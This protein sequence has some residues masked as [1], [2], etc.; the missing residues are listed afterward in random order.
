MGVLHVRSPSMNFMSL[1]IQGLAQKAKKDWV[2]EL[3]VNNKVNFLSLQETKMETIELFCIKRCWGIFAFDYV[4]SASVGNLSGILC[5]WDP[6]LFQKT[7]ITVSDY[8]VMIRGVWVPNGKKLRII[9]VYAHQELNEKKMLWDYISHVMSNWKCDVVI[10]GDFN[11][12]RKKAE[13]FGLVFNVQGA[14]A[15]N[16]FIS[17]ASLEEVPLGGCSFTWC[18][19]S[20]TKMSKLDRFLISE[21]LMSACPNISAITLDR[22]LSDHRPI[23][24]CES[25]YDY[26]PVPFRFF[27][28]WF[29]M[30]GFDKFV[31]ES[32]K[33]APVAEINA[34]I[35]M[36]KKLKYLKEKIRVW[37]KNK[38]ECP[39]NS[40]RNLKAEL[41]SVIDKGKGDDDVAIE[42]VENSKY[43][44]GILNKKRSQLAI[45]GILVDGNWID[46]PGLVKTDLE[47]E[48]IKEEIKRAVWDCGIDK[49]S[50]PD[51]F[52]FGFYRCVVV[53]LEAQ[54]ANMANTDKNTRTSKT[55]EARKGTNN[56]KQNFDDRRNTTTNNDNNYS[57]NR[58]NNN[59]RDNHNN[60]NL[61]NDY[62]QQENRKQETIRTYAATPTENKRYTKKYHGNLTLVQDAP[63][64]TPEFAQASVR[65][66]TMEKGHYKSQCS[67]TDNS[68]F[69]ISK[70]YLCDKSL[71]IPMKEIW[72]D[73][74]LNFVEEPVEIMDRE[75]K[76]LRRSSI[77]IVKV[78][79]NSE[80]T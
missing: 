38:K 59:Y 62:H 41:D 35:K 17:N 69:H 25:H 71:V 9:L 14:D 70:K 13:R 42:G 48:V 49:S 63:C 60:H 76:Q 7:N 54:A 32:W 2:K 61:N 79:W 64:I 27:H 58:N 53:A 50:G 10:M 21:S 12:V 56:H 55:Q 52:T 15:F 34:L 30:E 1:N 45:R 20:A 74:K 36:M 72:L 16:L 39:N 68:T 29:E 11:E 43:Y 67:K 4:Y 44:H 3:C 33:E 19:K 78:R 37:N 57:N 6:K 46:S 26:G 47:C 28:Y 22:Y 51:G 66:A 40:K 75:V 18:H 24:M 80:F 31:E 23:L 5:V 73:D 77:P 65:L 8:F